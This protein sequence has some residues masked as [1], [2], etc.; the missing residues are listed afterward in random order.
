MFYFQ[1]F[2]FHLEPKGALRMPA[3]NKG[4]VIRGG[5]G[6]TFRRIVCHANCREPE[7]CELRHMCPYTAV[8]HP[9]VPEGSAKISKNRD[10]PRPFVIK[11]PLE[12]KETYLPG[13]QL[14]FDLVLIGKSC[15][16]L[17]YFIV[18]FKELSQVGLGAGRTRL[19]LSLVESVGLNGTVAPVYERAKNLVQPLQQALSWETIVQTLGKDWTDARR[20]TLRFLTPTMIK[21]G[22]VF[23]RRPDFGTVFKRLRDRINA[24][25]YFYCGKGLQINFKVFGEQAER[26]KT[27]SDFTRW[28]ESAR[29]SRRREVAHDLSGFVGDVSFEGELAPFL[30]FLRLGEYLHVGKNAVFGNGWY[31]ITQIG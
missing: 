1:H 10:I 9:F 5:F 3:D 8:F 27:V 4:N 29:Y 6:S 25:S 21:T 26:I 22:G 2:R 31:E 16:Y 30:P 28:V 17:P 13:E 12:A 19:D 18:T 7:T 11:P 23:V 20:V 24:L 15:D 14:S